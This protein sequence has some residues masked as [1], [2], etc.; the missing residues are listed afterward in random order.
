[1]KTHYLNIILILTILSCNEVADKNLQPNTK[2]EKSQFQ[3]LS[4][5]SQIAIQNSILKIDSISDLVKL[6]KRGIGISTFGASNQEFEVD[7][8]LRNFGTYNLFDTTEAQRIEYL[9]ILDIMTEVEIFKLKYDSDNEKVIAFKTENEKFDF[10]NQLRVGKIFNP[11]I[12]Q[13]VT[14]LNNHEYQFEK[15]KLDFIISTNSSNEI[16]SITVGEFIKRIRD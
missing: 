3:T 4:E 15:N 16:Q 11:L 14:K 13:E 6:K 1:M 12:Y 7:K 10:G 2:I 8:K 9:G 5:K